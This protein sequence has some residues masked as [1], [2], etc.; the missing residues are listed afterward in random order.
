MC[1]YI[2]YEKCK[3]EYVNKGI[4]QEGLRK[5]GMIQDLAK[6]YY[7][8]GIDEILYIDSV[9]SLYNRNALLNILKQTVENNSAFV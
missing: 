7:N 3:N 6:K 2:V 5:V 9:A 4:H 1:D 8:G